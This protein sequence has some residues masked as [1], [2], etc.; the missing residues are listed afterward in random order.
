VK[1]SLRGRLAALLVVTGAAAARLL[2]FQGTDGF[3]PM[4]QAAQETVPGGTLVI[5]AY[6]F[7]WVA[8]AAYVFI[9]W[10]RAG[11][12]ERELT[13]LQARIGARGTSAR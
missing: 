6:A 9:V 8:L 1:A 10:R 7:A 2:A 4:S 5:A 13:D 11:R 12:I 3:V